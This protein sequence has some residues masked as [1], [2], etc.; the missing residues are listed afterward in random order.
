M[1]VMQRLTPTTMDPAQQ[2]IMTV[3]PIVFTVMFFAA[4]AGLNVYWLASNVCAIIQQAVTL[5]LIRGRDAGE[6]RRERRKR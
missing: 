1:F 4:P 6:S 3:M 5:R 2:R